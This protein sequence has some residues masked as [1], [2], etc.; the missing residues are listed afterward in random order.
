MPLEGKRLFLR[1]A[2]PAFVR[3]GIFDWWLSCCVLVLVSKF[4]YDVDVLELWLSLLSVSGFHA[5]VNVF[6]RDPASVFCLN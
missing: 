5:A 2:E 6:L 1:I 4:C 3:R